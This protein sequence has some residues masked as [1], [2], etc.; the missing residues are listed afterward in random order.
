[1]KNEKGI[2]LIQLS[3]IIVIG[4]CIAFGVLQVIYNSYQNVNLKRYVAKMQLI[5]EKVNLIRSKYKLW[6]NYNPNEAG[7]FYV[8]LQSLGFSNA[9]DS[10][11]EYIN[12]FNQ[13][14][15]TLNNSHL[16]N[17]DKNADSI[18]TNYCYFSSNDLQHYL[19]LPNMELDVIINF[20]SGNV[21]SR[22]NIYYDKKIIYRQYDTEIGNN[23]VVTPIYNSELIPKIEIIENYGLSQKIK[24][25]LEGEYSPKILDVYYLS[26]EQ[27]EIKKTCR[28]LSDYTYNLE[29]NAVYFNINTSGVYTFIVE[30]TNFIEYPKIEYEFNLCNP[31]KLEKGMT[32]IYWDENGVE[33]TI[34]NISDGN[35]YNYS[36]SDFRM[37]NAKTEDGNYW[38]WIPR[39]IYKQTT[40]GI[41]IEFVN[42][43][44]NIPTNNKA[45]IG[46]EVQKSFQENGEIEGF[47]IA[48]FQINIKD[49]EINIKPGKTL[50]VTSLENAKNNYKKYIN[51]NLNMDI[52]SEEEKNAALVMST[53]V[54]IDVANDLVHYAGGSPDE[55]KFKENIKYS[56]TNN[57]FGIYDLK[58]SENEITRNSKNSEIGRFRLVIY[59]K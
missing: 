40:E 9:N 8:Y 33:K 56:S 11:N 35:W 57:I 14:I 48:K 1:M 34:E 2:T 13:I 15:D 42:G 32:G 36:K 49:E 31:P 28:N 24:I 59:N 16:E 54:G 25:G 3:I 53:A 18:I 30:D 7:N 6:E 27:D 50:T 19:E 20:Y 46:Y 47:W 12:E 29:E 22:Q 44:N 58:T 55:E 37:A 5:Q 45:M 38:V 52:M 51:K 17:W 41:D 26:D 23:L 21:I 39:Y 4:I 10:T 43:I